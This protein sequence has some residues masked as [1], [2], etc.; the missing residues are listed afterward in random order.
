ML[1][2]TRK[3]A[4]QLVVRAA[5]APSMTLSAQVLRCFGSNPFKE[6]LSD[7]VSRIG[8][9]NFSVDERSIAELNSEIEDLLGSFDDD[10]PMQ[11]GHDRKS[12]CFAICEKVNS[13]TIMQ[14]GRDT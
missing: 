7:Y 14:F 13:L 10:E 2:F 8:N 11:F 1:F 6:S 9:D 4:H 12:I 3:Y 5:L